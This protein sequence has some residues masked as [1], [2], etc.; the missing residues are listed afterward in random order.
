MTQLAR[1][2]LLFRQK[3]TWS[4]H[5]LRQLQPPIYQYPVRIKELRESGMDIRG[6]DHP[7]EKKTY[8]YTFYEPQPAPKTDLFQEAQ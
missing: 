6:Y 4:N 3:H 8:L 5:E 2:A 1:L 7:T